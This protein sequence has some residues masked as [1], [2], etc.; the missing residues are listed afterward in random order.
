MLLLFL[1][2]NIEEKKKVKKSATQGKSH[3]HCLWTNECEPK[4]P[5]E[6]G[7]KKIQKPTHCTH[8]DI[9][10]KL[11]CLYQIHPHIFTQI[12]KNFLLASAP[13]EFD[14]SL[15]IRKGCQ[16]SLYNSQ[17]LKLLSSLGV[18]IRLE[19]VGVYTLFLARS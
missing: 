18:V 8:H 15:T 11:L 5:N 7:N 3:R 1:L 14:L 12:R 9:L 2:V 10:P 16:A 19:V 6:E 13:S 4:T 17:F